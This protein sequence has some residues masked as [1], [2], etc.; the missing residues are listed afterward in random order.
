M[1]RPFSLDEFLNRTFF[2]LDILTMLNDV[3][4]F[5]EFSEGN[6]ATQKQL[7]YNRT[8]RD[9]SEEEF[10]DPV[11]AAQY[12]D[13]MLESVH[14]RF[15][16]GLTQ[17]VRYAG[18]TAFI[19]T[20]EWCLLALKKRAAFDFP[21]KP[22]GT[23]EAVHALEV[24]NQKANLGVETKIEVLR[25]AIQV[26]NCIVHAAGL[27]GSFQYEASLR[28]QLQSL[29]GVKASTI[30]FLGESLEIEAGFLESLVEDFR[31]WL[32]DIEK[33]A[34]TQGLLERGGGPGQRP[35]KANGPKRS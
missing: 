33:T 14:Y 4:H 23:N 15:D 8:E 21:D 3:E 10:D 34:S 11:M 22:K 30:N 31:Q 1:K 7:E 17:R 16:V 35:S 5:I 32:P 9:C 26:R 6:I 25:A 29:P 2:G 27:L 24:F 18:L 19:T 13:Q 28:A 12:R 20:V